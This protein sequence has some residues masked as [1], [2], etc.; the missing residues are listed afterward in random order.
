MGPLQAPASPS[1]FKLTQL[2]Y[3]QYVS[4]SPTARGSLL[5]TISHGI[6]G[7]AGTP[8]A[9]F[10]DT[11]CRQ[12]FKVQPACQPHNVMDTTTDPCALPCSSLGTSLA[13]GRA[14]TGAHVA[15]QPWHVGESSQQA[16]HSANK[17]NA[18]A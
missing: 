9:F 13:Y 5:H 6:V 18:V 15:V 11:T 2:H 14:W 1:S 12:H 17:H 8:D 3:V 7:D 10:T 4:W 16:C